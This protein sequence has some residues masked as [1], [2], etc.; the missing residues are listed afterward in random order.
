M[1]SDFIFFLT[2]PAFQ[3]V[4]TSESVHEVLG[5]EQ[6]QIQQL[7]LVDL[8]DDDERE[9]VIDSLTAAV[10]EN[11]TASVLYLRLLHG[12]LGQGYVVCQMTVSVAGNVIV[13][14]ICRPEPATIGITARDQSAEEVI[15]ATDYVDY[16]N[17]TGYPAVNWTG[18]QSPRTALL[19]DR[20]GLNATISHCTN[21]AI[22]NNETCVQES[23]FSYVAERDVVSSFLGRLRRPSGA[24]DNTPASVGFLYDAFTLCV[25][26]RDSRA[27]NARASSNGVDEVR[28]SVVGS[29]SSD[30]LILV[31]KRES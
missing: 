26:G 6:E 31:L 4:Y 17:M 7:R 18:T 1:N 23:F 25:T 14:S 10:G 20:F 19:L 8:L 2:T 24:G 12:Q 11:K 27:S 16:S 5:F 29:A 30:G 21:N 22:L 3:F 13:G 9:D 28:V 15:V